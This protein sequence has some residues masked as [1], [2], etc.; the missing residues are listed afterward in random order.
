MYLKKLE[1][2]GFKSFVDETVLEFGP[3]ISVIVGPNGCG[4]SNLLDAIRWVLGEQSPKILRCDRMAD[5]IWNGSAV[6]PA[7][8]L[9]EVSLTLAETENVLPLGYNEVT[10]TRRLFRS[11]ESEY[12]INKVP[13]R[14][15]DIEELF[16]DTGI[17]SHAYAIMEQG[18]MDLLLSQKPQERRF[19][20]E[21][22]A[23]ITKYETRKDEAIRKLER[24]EQNLLRLHDV[25]AEVRKQVSLVERAAR[26]TQRYQE[27]FNE[28]KLLEIYLHKTEYD[29]LFTEE[30]T[31]Q[32][33]LHQLQDEMSQITVA[34]DKLEAEQETI[35]THLTDSEKRLLAI[36]QE[37]QDIDREMQE[38]QAQISIAKN[39]ITAADESLETI[40]RDIQQINE[41]I[42]E[43]TA[44]V[45]PIKQECSQV[46]EQEQKIEQMV[47]E[48]TTTIE[49]LA[50]QLQQL[51]QNV[52]ETTLSIAAQNKQ[53][54][55]LRELISRINANL[56]SIIAQ[57]HQTEQNLTHKQQMVDE[58]TARVA[59]LRKQLEN[60]EQIVSAGKEKIKQQQSVKQQLLQQHQKLA[61]ILD[62]LKS[63]YNNKVARKESLVALRESFEGY[64]Q[65]PKTL[66]QARETFPGLLGTVAELIRPEA[67]YEL[68]LAAALETA[69][70][71]LVIE[72]TAVAK[73]V[74][75]FLKQKK[76][77]RVTILILDQLNQTNQLT[78]PTEVLTSPG[79]IGLATD[80]AA[81]DVKYKAVVH[82]VLGNTL[83]VDTLDTAFRIMSQIPE[84]IQCVTL[85][86][87][88][89]TSSGQ[90]SSGIPESA[91]LFAR[92]RELHELIDQISQLE[93][94]I[95]HT[96][97]QLT[98][99]TRQIEQNQKQVE[100][101]QLLLFD[102]ELEFTG[103]HRDLDSLIKQQHHAQNEV[104][105]VSV[106]L[107]NLINDEQKLIAQ[108]TALSK[109]AEE[110]EKTLKE[111]Q[112]ALVEF[113]NQIET[114]VKNKDGKIHEL[115]AIQ[116]QLVEIR[117]RKQNLTETLTR[118]V[119]E[120]N[121]R[122][123]E[124]NQKNILYQTYLDKKTN[125][126][127]NIQTAEDRLTVL[128]GKKDEVSKRLIEL[129]QER[130]TL[131]QSL[132]TL[133]EKIQGYRRDQNGKQ[134]DLRDCEIQLAQLRM[135]METMY[136]HI[137][138]TYQTDLRTCQVPELPESLSA[139]DSTGKES[140]IHELK[141]KIQRV[142]PVSPGSIEEYE[143][144][145]QRLE[146]LT[147]QEK[148]LTDAK[149]QLIA[150][151][152]HINRTTKERFAETF[153]RIQANF[154]EVFRQVF[155]GGQAQLTLLDTENINE[156]GIEIMVNP[157]G[158][159]LQSITL[160]S[161][162]EK[163]LSAI[164]LLFA[165]YRLKP[166]PFCVLDE[167]DAPLDDVNI[168][169]FTDLIKELTTQSQFIIMTH[170][171]RTME[172]ADVLYGVTMEEPGVSKVIAVK[173]TGQAWYGGELTLSLDFNKAILPKTK[174]V[175]ETKVD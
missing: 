70:Q 86:G 125:A 88:T 98:S 11:G 65:G 124:L 79:V 150:T 167:I 85:E 149:E 119:N 29:R 105:A 60:V 104:E 166:S 142:G 101:Q 26:A 75:S 174:E 118:I 67:N 141:S 94:Q 61:G 12:L 126:E 96:T 131:N 18:K 62:Q 57:K 113:R 54:T 120:I 77:G 3:G 136:Q 156:S 168:G 45:D 37:R 153:A 100:Q 92:D 138:E 43:L 160:L 15:K 170:N 64:Y 128:L 78:I 31:Q 73:Q 140:R 14:L 155:R 16:M 81:Y 110:L 74:M 129:Q 175:T 154:H 33:K 49:Q 93:H 53:Y 159:K 148:D 44:S 32:G 152:T 108:K 51:E 133:A 151:I 35:K 127:K 103:L 91:Q 87:D 9:A 106:I 71:F 48:Q 2:L 147:Q 84:G 144:L 157:P 56:E 20:F 21:E 107:S 143:T 34:I 90:I 164:A 7:T 27:Y 42:T 173:M 139:L 97:S 116:I 10:V 135:R 4:K 1:L 46:A 6:R 22:A 24:T 39:Q 137:L 130:D 172:A 68:A 114:V 36:Q 89:V 40:T 132:D 59:T 162:G 115:T 5:I 28:L 66:L 8:S 55:E 38:Q 17:G 112:A 99:V 117:N 82:W 63:E 19:V 123:I 23:G 25:I 80:L 76:S 111:N 109:Q 83:V 134:N 122:N 52:Q 121:E 58:L 165:I 72:N 30:Q 47:A 145:K 50:V 158:K 163:A 169:R 171:K 13:C 69:A 41:R 146:F 95:D 161:G 102:S